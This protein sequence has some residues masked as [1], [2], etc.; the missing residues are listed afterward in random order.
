M[1]GLRCIGLLKR[2]LKLRCILKC[3]QP[4]GRAECG[5]DLKCRIMNKKNN[6]VTDEK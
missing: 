2:K 1:S 6:V 4:A 3:G 5:R